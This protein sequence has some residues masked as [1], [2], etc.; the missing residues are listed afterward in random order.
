MTLSHAGRISALLQGAGYCGACFRRCRCAQPPAD[1]WHSSSAASGNE[2]GEQ[3]EYKI[4]EPITLARQKSALLPIVNQEIDGTRVSIYNQ[5][6]ARYALLGMR[7]KNSTGLHLMQGPITVYESGTYAGDAQIA[8]VRRGETR[9]ISYA[10]DLSMDVV[11]NAPEVRR[12]LA[13]MRIGNGE[14][15]LTHQLQRFITYDLHNRSDH[16]KLVVIE[17]PREEKWKLP[18]DQA[19]VEQGRDRYRFD[20]KVEAKK[21]AKFKVSE[22]AAEEESMSLSRVDDDRIRALIAEKVSTPPLRT[23]LARLSELREQVAATN[24]SNRDHSGRAQ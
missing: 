22:G 24:R 15:K 7:F 14:L 12:E 1:F 10:V 6:V 9:L 8:D 19:S 2:V 23:A 11:P 3:F 4:K 13:K 20:V 5:A 17:H 18:D 21:S 16:E